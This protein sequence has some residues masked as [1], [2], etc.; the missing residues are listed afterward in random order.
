MLVA[1]CLWWGLLMRLS[2]ED[3]GILLFPFPYSLLP[4]NRADAAGQLCIMNY[5]LLLSF[6]SPGWGRGH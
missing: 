2:Q 5:E 1:A 3:K 6:S 4:E